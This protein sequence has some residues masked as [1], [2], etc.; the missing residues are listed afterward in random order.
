MGLLRTGESWLAAEQALFSALVLTR[1]FADASLSMRH[2]SLRSRPS[3]AR[4]A[5][6]L[7]NPGDVG[8]NRGEDCTAIPVGFA[9]FVSTT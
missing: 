8:N 5:T 9:A 1:A 7:S 4:G 2:R 6:L 3:A